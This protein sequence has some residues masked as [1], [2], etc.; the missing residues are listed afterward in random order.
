MFAYPLDMQK[1]PL[2]WIRS[3]TTSTITVTMAFGRRFCKGL[4]K[5]VIVASFS[6]QKG[7]EFHIG[8]YFASH[9]FGDWL[10]VIE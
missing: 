4:Q 7:L 5:A 6:L 10:V 9:S 1:T 3:T 8:L 2:R